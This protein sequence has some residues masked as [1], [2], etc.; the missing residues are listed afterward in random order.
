MSAAAADVVTSNRGD[1]TLKYWATDVAGNPSSPVSADFVVFSATGIRLSSTA[2]TISA[3]QTLRIAGSVDPSSAPVP[4]LGRKMR[5]QRYVGGAW[6]SGGV[7]DVGLW[8]GGGFYFYVKPMDNAMYR[9]IVAPGSGLLPGASAN[10][11]VKVRAVLS[12]PSIT[13]YARA[14]VYFSATGTSVPH[15][16]SFVV[17]WYRVSSTGR[18]SLYGSPR[19]V[20]ASAGRWTL[21]N[22]LPRGRWAVRAAHSDSNHIL[23]YSP[24]RVFTVH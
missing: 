10:A 6:I 22:K 12:T 13:S 24:Y 21:R 3:G 11:R 16:A 2:A 23:S 4:L 18:L 14:N 7:P 5:L 19:S 8:G 9:V 15:V 1:H 20:T 17:S